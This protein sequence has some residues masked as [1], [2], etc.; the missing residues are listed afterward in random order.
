MLPECFCEYYDSQYE[1]IKKNYFLSIETFEIEGVHDL[2]VEIKRLRAFFDLIEWI[3]PYFKSK[4]KFKEIR[5]LFKAAGKIRDIHV[6]QELTRKRIS[7]LNLDLSEYYNLLKQK[8]LAARKGFSNFCK[9]FDVRVFE[10][11]REEIRKYLEIIDLDYIKFKTEQRFNRLI[12][13][14]IDF[15]NKEILAEKDFHTIRILSKETRYTLEILQKCFPTKE[16]FNDLNEKIRAI[17]QALGK[18]HDNDVGLQFLEGMMKNDT[19]QTFFNK[20]S[21]VEFSKG[22]GEEN[23]ALLNTFEEK[24]NDFLKLLQS[25]NSI[26]R[27]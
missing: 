7:L 20:K 13:D 15:K 26:G 25:H 27:K 16:Y 24:W 5:K 6:Q 2:R 21:Y 3:N 14:L 22:L 4:K 18:W 1:K 19:V 10:A 9:K 17:H 23:D 12:D 11:K 8:E